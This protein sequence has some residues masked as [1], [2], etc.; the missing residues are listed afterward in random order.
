[1]AVITLTRENFDKEVM[2]AKETVLIDFWA[3]WCGPCRMLSP[4]VDEIA[5]EEWEGV[6]ICKV[7]VDDQPILAQQF[8]VMSIPT[9]VVCKDGKQ[10]AYAVG[11]KTKQEIKKMIAGAGQIVGN[12]Q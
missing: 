3:S 10:A 7:N 5:Q 8:Q 6:K 12:R 4:I 1:M 9:L 11:V 2:Q